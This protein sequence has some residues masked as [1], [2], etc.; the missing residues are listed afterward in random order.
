MNVLNAR[1]VSALGLAGIVVTFAV[2]LLHSEQRRSGTDLTPNGA[3]VG[4][5]G[6]GQEAC[7][8]QELLPADTSAVRM[9]IGTRGLPG[10]PIHMTLSVPGGRTVTNGGLAAGWHQG[11]VT[12]PVKRVS[13]PTPGLRACLRNAG[14][15][16]IQLAG[17][18]PDPGYHF[19][20]AG[21]T[22][23]GRLRYDYLRP[24]R[25]SWLELLPTLAY[26]STIAKS[27][28]VRHWAWAGAVVL[29]LLAA[30]FAVA[31]IVRE[32]RQ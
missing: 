21:G 6:A 11:V 26:R 14:P 5:V 22:V 20:L 29:M 31:T 4:F 12:I 10:P 2:L 19:E 13:E 18:T 25:E 8:E 15:Q 7:Q 27:D 16:Q 17:T 23:E 32:A 9:T 3:F 28:L 1:V 30:G 24:G